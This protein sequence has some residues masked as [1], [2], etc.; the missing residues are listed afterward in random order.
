MALMPILT[1]PDSR[2]REKAEPVDPTREDL[3]TLV[4]DMAE[5]MYHAVGVGLAATQVGVTKR[6]V[7]IDCDPGGEES[8]L[9]PL[10]NPEILSGE[11]DSFEEEGCLSVPGYAAKVKRFTRVRARWQDLQGV[12]HEVETDGLF[13]IAIQHEIDHLDGKLFVDYLSPLKRELF[14]K[15][16]KKMHAQETE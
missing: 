6:V 15:R 14:R 10:I 2:L 12:A 13:A 7:V 1:Y 5:T 11:G 3:E 16:Y 9:I 8:R 4:T